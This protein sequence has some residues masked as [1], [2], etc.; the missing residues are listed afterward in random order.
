MTG[1]EAGKLPSLTAPR[2]ELALRRRAWSLPRV[3]RW[4]GE[5]ELS[6]QP[7]YLLHLRRKGVTVKVVRPPEGK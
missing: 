4:G 1:A 6:L 7:F 3:M 5:L 2:K